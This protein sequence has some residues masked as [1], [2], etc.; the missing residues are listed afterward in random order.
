MFSRETRFININ[1][2]HVDVG[3]ERAIKLLGDAKVALRMLLDE[4]K[5]NEGWK[6][7]KH[8]QETAYFEEIR[9][10][11]EKWLKERERLC[12]LGLKPMAQSE[13][14]GI[15]NDFSQPTDVV[16]SAAGS[17]PGDLLKL[18][19][20]RDPDRKGYHVEFGYSCMGYEIAGG[21]GIKLASPDRHVYVM[22][23]DAS[24][25]M[26]SQEIVT[27]VQERIGGITI[28][29]VDNFGPQCI[30]HLQK[31]NK[32]QEF[33]NEFKFREAGKL[34]GGYLKIDYVE[35]CKGMGAEA[36]RAETR[37]D[38]RKA[39]EFARTVKNKP[40][41]IHVPANPEVM[42]PNYGGWWD[43]P[44]PEVSARKELQEQLKVYREAKARQVVR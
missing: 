34:E 30:R 16:V 31:G 1:I 3:K 44:I 33:G 7:F 32:L 38:L 18:W 37:E 42:V 35:I 4:L 10:S 41:V 5:K 23:G 40:V 8:Y 9:K 2:C 19:K 11:R 39:L 28:V 27:M 29:V 12:N 20:C 21:M 15:V 17:L 36:L 24:F 25:L 26:A 22:V 13:I 14:I 6:T 43:V